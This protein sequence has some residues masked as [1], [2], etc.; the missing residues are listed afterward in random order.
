MLS[1][2]VASHDVRDLKEKPSAKDLNAPSEAKYGSTRRETTDCV[3][4][5]TKAAKPKEARP[6]AS[7]HYRQFLPGHPHCKSSTV[8]GL[9]PQIR[10][11]QKA[12]GTMNLET[13][14]A[15][16]QEHG[17]NAVWHWRPPHT[18][19]PLVDPCLYPRRKLNRI[20]IRFACRTS[21]VGR[22]HVL[23]CPLPLLPLCCLAYLPWPLV[24]GRV[25]ALS[26]SLLCAAGA[27]LLGRRIFSPSG[28]EFAGPQNTLALPADICSVILCAR[29]W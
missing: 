15:M 24:G 28:Q 21:G 17:T 29:S 16:H 20:L 5:P 6:A 11:R 25:G 13:E 8:A 9:G 1:A 22:L 2:A 18:S 7:I 27:C 19:I 10:K 14:A 23:V 26:L 12:I 4:S 3:A